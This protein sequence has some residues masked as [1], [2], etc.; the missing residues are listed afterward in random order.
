MAPYRNAVV[1][2]A[3][4]FIRPERNAQILTQLLE[5]FGKLAKIVQTEQKAAPAFGCF[6]R[7][8]HGGGQAVQQ[9]R[10][11]FQQYRRHR[12]HIQCMVNQQV[13]A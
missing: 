12:C 7:Q 3:D 9:F 13:M 8:T 6:R 4:V 2:L 1:V 10:A 5:G 11:L